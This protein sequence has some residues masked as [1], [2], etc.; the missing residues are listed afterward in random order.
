MNIFALDDNPF[1]AAQAQCDK[2]VVKMTLETAQ[3]LSTVHHTHATKAHP[4]PTGIYAPTHARHPSTLWTAETSGNYTWLFAHFMA[5]ADEYTH[6]F[7]KTH[8]SWGD[9]CQIL[10]EPPRLI[11]HAPRT[12]FAQAMPDQFKHSDPVTAYRAYYRT[13]K[14][15]LL[16]YTRRPAP[17]WLNQPKKEL[18]A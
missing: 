2:H 17:A 13:A 4:A 5:L 16:S 6:R 9:L 14:A 11:T 8:K 10:C 3:L 12:A 18:A 7:F 15:D 1:A